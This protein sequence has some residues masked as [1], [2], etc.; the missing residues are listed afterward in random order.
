M[1]E[2][3]E[4]HRSFCLEQGLP[5]GSPAYYACLAT[6]ND[7]R[8][9]IAALFALQQQIDKIRFKTDPEFI[10]KQVAWWHQQFQACNQQNADHPCLVILQKKLN[11]AHWNEWLGVLV[12]LF[13]EQQEQCEHQTTPK[14]R[15]QLMFEHIAFLLQPSIA[16]SKELHA[17]CQQLQ[18]HRILQ[19]THLD[20][21]RQYCPYNESLL[22][23][24]EI[25]WANITT[26]P[27][28]AAQFFKAQLDTHIDELNRTRSACQHVELTPLLIYNH[29]AEL[30]ATKALKHPL[31]HEQVP[32]I[33]PL[34]LLW[35]AWWTHYRLKSH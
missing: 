26:A 2:I 17:L 3:I 4:S 31:L 5:E 16:H 6:D 7:T 34:R 15:G 35:I 22:T 18:Q 23:E 1:A 33:S 32:S 28:Q 11:P 10:E 8:T 20:L 27:E 9:Y 14:H 24:H 19:Q 21:E 25:S 29:I 12:D 13:Y 30:W